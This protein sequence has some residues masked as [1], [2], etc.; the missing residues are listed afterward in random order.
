MI[1]PP[2]TQDFSI[3]QHDSQLV[4]PPPP[5]HFTTIKDPNPTL[6]P[7]PHQTNTCKSILI[8][9]KGQKSIF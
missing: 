5:S 2:P 4:P 7:P 6:P 1:I 3:A 9:S 8:L